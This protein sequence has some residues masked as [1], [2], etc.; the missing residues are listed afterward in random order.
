MKILIAGDYCPIGKQNIGCFESVRSHFEEC[1]LRILNFECAY[2]KEKSKKIKKEGVALGCSD[3]EFDQIRNLPIDLITLANNHVMDYGDDGLKLLIQR[4][5]EVGIQTVGAGVKPS[6]VSRPYVFGN[7]NGNVAIVNCCE[8]EFSVSDSYKPGANAA[9]PVMVYNQIQLAKKKTNAVIVIMHGGHEY[10]QLPSPRIQNVCRFFIDAGACAVIGHHPH[11]YSGMEQYNNGLIF[12]SL[13]N[14][15]FPNNKQNHSAWNEGFL[16]KLSI[17][18][19]KHVVSNF[20]AIPYIQCD[21][22]NTVRAVEG[23][24]RTC[25]F[26]EFERL[27]N[28][29]AD[30]ILVQSYFEDFVVSMKRKALSRLLPYSNHYLIALYKRGLFPSFLNS[31]AVVA[32]LNALQCESHR[33]I[34]IRILKKYI[35]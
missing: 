1:D 13:G 8:S 26:K 18:D 32:R 16:V 7:N 30:E 19:A 15:Y 34:I 22:T 3:E 20:E 28:I 10:Y 27:T 4:A 5:N 6:E 14:F 9:D 17:D 11:C 2:R 12:Y 33:D 35:R 29:I 23:E 25:F 31:R 24:E 21:E